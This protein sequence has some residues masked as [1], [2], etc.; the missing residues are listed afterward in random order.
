MFF[1][2]FSTEFYCFQF[3]DVKMDVAVREL[4]FVEAGMGGRMILESLPHP[5]SA[6]VGSG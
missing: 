6:G 2:P 3:R 4:A 5:V 1:I